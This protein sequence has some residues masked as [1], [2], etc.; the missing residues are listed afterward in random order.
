MSLRMKAGCGDRRK[1]LC[2]PGGVW[3]AKPNL[4]DGRKVSSKSSCISLVPLDLQ[5]NY[6]RN[7][8]ANSVFVLPYVCFQEWYP[9][10][11]RLGKFCIQAAGNDGFSTDWLLDGE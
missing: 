5:I 11:E 7:P 9:W 10:R 8:A 6:V 3:M 2:H 1:A 4:Q